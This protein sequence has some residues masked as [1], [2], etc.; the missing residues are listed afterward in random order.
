LY[1]GTTLKRLY[2]VDSANVSSNLKP[3]DIT[4][5][6]FPSAYISC[7]AV[8]P[9][10]ADRVMVSFSNYNV[11][12]IFSS[13]DGGKTWVKSAGNLEQ[14][15]TGLGDGP[16]VRWLSV[17]PVEDGTV[18]LAATSAGFFATD[19]LMGLNTKWVQQASGE[20]GNM[21]C[22]MFDVRSLDGTI[23]LATHGNGIYTARMVK[24]GDILSAR[25]VQENELIQ[26]KLFPNPAVGEVRISCNVQLLGNNV[27]QNEG[28][29]QANVDLLDVY[30]R[31]LKSCAMHGVNT[32]THS[33]FEANMSLSAVSPG[34]Y[35]VRIKVGK[36]L[37]TLPLFVTSVR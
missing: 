16:S 12:S 10:N 19:T 28:V 7:L 31:V 8:D 9:R 30:G 1:Y 2:R 26:A 5:T 24:R 33:G 32:M 3:K 29:L 20:I 17:L 11:Y 23:A 37:K 27:K 25:W 18:Y 15:G 4:A 22:D 6:A 35:Y 14:F 34:Q 36:A 21:V 13:E